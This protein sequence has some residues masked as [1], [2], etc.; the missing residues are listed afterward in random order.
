MTL[1]RGGTEME[2]IVE[3]LL[4]CV[5]SMCVM[6]RLQ[7]AYGLSIRR[8]KRFNLDRSVVVLSGALNVSSN[9]SFHFV[10]QYLRSFFLFFNCMVCSV[11]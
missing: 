3:R 5:L 2:Y 6:R 11:Y 9:I 8:S 10:V 1:L 7:Y 4:C